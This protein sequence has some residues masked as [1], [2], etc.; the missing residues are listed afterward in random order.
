MKWKRVIS[1]SVIVVLVALNS[2]SAKAIAADIIV[3][4][5]N[6]NSSGLVVFVYDLFGGAVRAVDGSPFSLAAGEMSLRFT[7]QSGGN[8]EGQI[9][10][11]VLKGPVLSAAPPSDPPL[12][13]PPLS[14]QAPLS[15]QSLLS[16]IVVRDG[17]TV[18]VR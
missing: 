17:D 14:G 12:S 18:E 11:D 6:E 16:G 3:S 4:I 9:A 13:D 1:T 8:G 10:Y 2:L 5:T 15:G 7:V